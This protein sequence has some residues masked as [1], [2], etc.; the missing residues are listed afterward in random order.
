VRDAAGIR[1][2]PREILTAVSQMEATGKSISAVS[3][4]SVIAGTRG[5]RSQR[6]QRHAGEWRALGA[7]LTLRGL[8][9]SPEG[10][11]AFVGEVRHAAGKRPSDHMLL[12]VANSAAE[13]DIALNTTVIGKV[14]RRLAST[15]GALDRD[16]LR[17]A[18]QHEVRMLRRESTRGTG[19]IRGPRPAGS[20]STTAMTRRWR[21]GGR[22]NRT[23]RKGLRG[24]DTR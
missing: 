14:A 23:A 7:L 1:I 12:R 3:V 2:S 8:D 16:A 21:P 17:V 24:R 19:R 18:V 4:A 15:A 6:Q 11:L 5:T 13:L 9:G 22:K 10:Q 20:A